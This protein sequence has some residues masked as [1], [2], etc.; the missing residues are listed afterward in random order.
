MFRVSL[1]FFFGLKSFSFS[2]VVTDN[3]NGF[4]FFWVND[5]R[6]VGQE[7]ECPFFFGQ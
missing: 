1:F 5:N 4:F 6:N 3:R 2:S 7:N